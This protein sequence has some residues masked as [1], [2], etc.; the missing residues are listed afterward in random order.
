MGEGDNAAGYYTDYSEETAD[1]ATFAGHSASRRKPRYR[2]VEENLD[3]FQ[4]VFG[5]F[6]PN[7]ASPLTPALRTPP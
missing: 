2:S 6:C 3:D 7:A 1:F 4:T 5:E